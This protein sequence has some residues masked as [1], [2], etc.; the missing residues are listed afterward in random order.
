MSHLTEWHAYAEM[1]PAF[2]AAG[3]G[4]QTSRQKRSVE[5]ADDGMEETCP[6][7]E[8]EVDTYGGRDVTQEAK[9]SKTGDSTGELF[10]C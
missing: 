1:S 7:T 4:L 8:T 10:C 9:R 5:D 3:D 2:D 6:A